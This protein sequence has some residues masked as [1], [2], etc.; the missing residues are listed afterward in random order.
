MQIS[1][2]G[3]GVCKHAHI[4]YQPIPFAA[5]TMYIGGKILDKA[6]A[7]C[8]NCAGRPVLENSNLADAN[9]LTFS[10]FVWTVMY[11]TTAALAHSK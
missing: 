6:R 9:D 8:Q 5:S 7:I 1:E 2:D 4:L 3:T 10:G 11:G